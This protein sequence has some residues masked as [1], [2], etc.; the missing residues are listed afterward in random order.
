MNQPIPSMPNASEDIL[1]LRH[2]IEH[3]A[4]IHSLDLTDKAVVTRI[5]DGDMSHCRLNTGSSGCSSNDALS[6]ELPT[7]LRLLFRLEASSSEDLGN[8]GL[9][10]LWSQYREILARFNARKIMPIT[11]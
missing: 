5:L 6:E 4:S 10:K 8:S 3:I 7:M 2:L 11:S 1:A 9:R